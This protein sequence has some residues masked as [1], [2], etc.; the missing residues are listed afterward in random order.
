LE[1]IQLIYAPSQETLF[2]TRTIIGE[3]GEE[4]EIVE[5]IEADEEL[6]DAFDE[7]LPDF[8]DGEEFNVFD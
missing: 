4:I 2:S 1:K 3:D 7:E 8:L 5:P 6:D